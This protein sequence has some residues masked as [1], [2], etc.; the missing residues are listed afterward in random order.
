MSSV[1]QDLAQAASNEAIL[2]VDDDPTNLQMLVSTLE[3]LGH[4]LL[5]AKN[6]PTAL[7]L[8]RKARPD[9]ILLDIVMDEMDG[10][11]VCEE[12]KSDPGTSAIPVLFLSA[13]DRVEEK[14]R[15]FGLGAVD[16]TSKPFQPEEVVARVETH[17]TIHRLRRRLE[18]ANRD[19]AA[20]NQR[21]KRDLEA[22]ADVQRS[23]LPDSPDRAEQMRFAW[24]Y[25][26]CDELAGDSLN[27][28]RLDRRRLGLYVLDVSGHGVPAS[29]LSVAV[30]R[31]LT[32]RTDASCLV[33]DLDPAGER[34]VPVEPAEV[35]RRL[36]VLY[37]MSGSASLYF[38]IVYGVLDLDAQSFTFASAGHPGPMVVRE[39]EADI[40]GSTGTPIGIVEDAEFG[41]IE[42]PLEAG[43]RLYLYS[44]GLYE[45]R[46]AAAEQYGPERLREAAVR[47]LEASLDES[48]EALVE[49]V[50]RWRGGTRLSDDVAII[51]L[52]VG[53]GEG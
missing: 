3:Q 46:D 15:G 9:L 35:L 49:D 43:D 38:T 4:R 11:E 14:V 53:T 42:I 28:L 45:E 12:L 34:A 17:L 22:A 50:L 44:D 29:L 40:R 13:L 20:A 7:A 37:P 31:S 23:L 26:P 33:S 19:L 5:V 51:G 30:T 18:H 25:R 48:V 8:A 27:V 16:Y 39:G 6:G 47:R 24:R 52:E 36:N 10:F 41:Q 21:M 2:L 32:P 1:T